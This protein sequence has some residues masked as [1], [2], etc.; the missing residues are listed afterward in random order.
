MN[1]LSGE[2]SP[3]L[4]QHKDNPVHWQVWGEEALAAAQAA[5][6][7][8]LLSIGY[9]ACHWCHVMAAES[10]ENAETAALV[11]DLFVPIKVDREERP[12][13]DLIYQ[14]A[15]TLLGQRGGWPLTMFLTPQGEPFWGGT[16]YPPESR[17]GR[18]AFRD[19][20]S[21]AAQV[22]S[23]QKD[24]VEKNTQVLRAGLARLS[25]PPPDNLLTPDILDEI[26]LKFSDLIDEVDG[27]IGQAPKFP[28]SP[29]LALLWR[30]YKRTG[31]AKLRDG[32]LLTLDRMSQ[33]GIYDH[34]GGGYSRYSTD[35]AWLVPHFEKML[36]DNAQLVELLT[37]AWQETG[38]PLYAERITETVAWMLREMRVDGGAFAA[39]LD[40][41]SEHEE[42]K[43]YVWTAAEVER[44]LGPEAALFKAHY[45]VHR[46]GNWEGRSILNRSEKPDLADPATES[47]LAAARE[48]L[49]AARDGRVRPGRDHK[50]LADWNGLAISA[51]CLAG[52]ALGREDW[53][54]AAG[55]AFSFI[56]AQMTNA[57]GRLHHSWCA[58]RTHPGLLDDY[59]A[60]SRAALT[61][62]QTRSD[63][64][65]LACAETWVEHLEAQFRDKERG[66]Y[67]LTPQD[68]PGLIARIRNA[69]DHATSSGNGM[70]VEVFSTLFLLTGK[71]EYRARAERQIG[72]FAGEVARNAI[73]L[74]A[75][76]SGLDAFANSVQIVIRAGTGERELLD[77]VQA[78]CIPNRVLRV[79]GAG[80]QTPLGHPAHGK[81]SISGKATAYVCIGDTC[82]L[83][84]TDPELLQ[85]ALSGRQAPPVGQNLEVSHV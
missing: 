40:A 7:P 14:N 80:E 34:L 65:Y 71:G 55:Q 19:M 9:A 15:L 58:G 82:S 24:T 75:F 22:Y 5:D 51:L 57:R 16:Y 72:A 84:V 74:A 18:P 2:T 53:I 62:Y 52:G 21:R 83:P 48:K 68:A 73:P 29:V 33:G 3:Y 36:Y 13:L 44:V 69:F 77:A 76:L 46:I 12:D 66:G 26:C 27:G 1:H 11:N 50:V 20:L 79:L 42:G 78:C 8:I 28:Q 54:E 45:D 47:R 67:F 63:P 60:M 64:Y 35:N 23:G 70:M 49:L 10:F 37:W 30:G 61:L 31:K 17:Y 81:E 38:N 39:A 85:L 25:E 59:A 43:F 56:L 6:K 32:V 41:D 4:L